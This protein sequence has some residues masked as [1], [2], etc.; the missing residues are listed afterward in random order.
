MENV[1]S[2]LAAVS[3]DHFAWHVAS[4]SHSK[5]LCSSESHWRS[6]E[7]CWNLVP[8]E[9]WHSWPRSILN[10]RQ[11][12]QNE[13]I[14]LAW[15]HYLPVDWVGFRTRATQALYL[16]VANLCSEKILRLDAESRLLFGEVIASNQ[17]LTRFA[18]LP[19]LHDLFSNESYLSWTLQ[20]DANTA[21]RLDR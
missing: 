15:R 6:I 12:L 14:H 3:I 21:E 8:M 7:S 17:K 10:G 19:W 1:A 11:T 9:R 13:V 4:R 16:A 5:A 18:L 2:H 20:L